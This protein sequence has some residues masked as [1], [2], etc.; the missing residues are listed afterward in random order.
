MDYKIKTQL[1]KRSLCEKED[2]SSDVAL[3][4]IPRSF[5]DQRELTKSKPKG[6]E[7][8]FTNH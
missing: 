4:V 8:G 5:D 3:V 6:S 7:A 2:G 1:I